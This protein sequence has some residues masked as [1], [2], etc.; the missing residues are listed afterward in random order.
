MILIKMVAEKI[1]NRK[2]L[3]IGDVKLATVG[4]AFLGLKGIYIAMF[5]AFL[6]SGIYSS[7]MLSK[8]YFKKFQSF[9]FAPFISFGILIVWIFGIEWWIQK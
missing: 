4:G 5:I 9:A 2:A 3:G 6:I 8:G 1:I 7:I